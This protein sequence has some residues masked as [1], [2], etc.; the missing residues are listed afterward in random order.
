MMSRPISVNQQGDLTPL[1]RS[2]LLKTHVLLYLSLP[3]F[4]RFSRTSKY[5]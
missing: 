5:A 3:D 4:E 2:Q 1:Y